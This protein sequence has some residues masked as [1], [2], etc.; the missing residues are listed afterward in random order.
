L[1]GGL[2]LKDFLNYDLDDEKR[3]IASEIFDMPEWSYKV[4][5][6]PPGTGKTTLIASIACELAREGRRS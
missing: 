4:V 5:E 3:K 6:G 2:G 1:E